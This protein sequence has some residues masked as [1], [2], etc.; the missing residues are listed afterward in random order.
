MIPEGTLN[1]LGPS[2]VSTKLVLSFSLYMSHSSFYETETQ[3][4]L[5]K[6]PKLPNSASRPPPRVAE[7]RAL[8][9]FIFYTLPAA[10]FVWLAGESAALP[11][12]RMAS[13]F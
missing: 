2:I 12:L 11:P 1:T 3:D 7:P 6:T 13:Q 4:F 10:S 9:W 5:S 8:G